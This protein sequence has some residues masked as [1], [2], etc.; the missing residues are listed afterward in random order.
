MLCLKKIIKIFIAFLAV[1]A[2]FLF[3][4]S[5]HLDRPKDNALAVLPGYRDEDS[6]SSLVEKNLDSNGCG[7]SSN[8]LGESEVETDYEDEVFTQEA[9]S[10]NGENNICVIENGEETPDYRVYAEN[11]K[12]YLVIKKTP[13]EETVWA[14]YEVIRNQG[15]I[16]SDVNL[17]WVY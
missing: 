7:C 9:D 14:A 4:P 6:Q 1:A 11:G 5:S 8:I 16:L 15:C 13:T 17:E 3:F 12:V 10:I 2:F